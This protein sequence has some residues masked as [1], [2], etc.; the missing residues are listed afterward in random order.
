MGDG[1]EPWLT[2]YVVD[3]YSSPSPFSPTF[4]VLLLGFFRFSF[5]GD[6]RTD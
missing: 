6:G 3:F 1:S 2:R 4:E 5:S